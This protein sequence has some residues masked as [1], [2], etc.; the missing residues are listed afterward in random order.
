MV[1]ESTSPG[2]VGTVLQLGRIL[3][4]F[5]RVMSVMCSEAKVEMAQDRGALMLGT[6]LKDDHVI[7]C[8]LLCLL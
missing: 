4:F 7:M 6:L 1:H 2:R 3:Q 8:C 5:N